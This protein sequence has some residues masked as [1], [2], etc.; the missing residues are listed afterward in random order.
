VIT[1]GISGFDTPLSLKGIHEI[2]AALQSVNTILSFYQTSN[3]NKNTPEIQEIIKEAIQYAN[4]NKDFENFDRLLFITR[5]INSL[6]QKLLV[7][8]K[9]LQIPVITNIY[10]LRGDIGTI[11][12]SAAFNINYFAPDANSYVSSAKISLGK[13]LFND[14]ILSDNNKISCASCHHPSKAFTDGFTKSMALGSAGFLGRNTPS[15]IN[16]GLQ[17]SQFYDMRATY[18]EDQVKNVIENK[19]EIHGS[20]KEAVIQLNRDSEYPGLF[21]TAFPLEKTGINE[22]VIQVAL[23]SYIRSLTSSNA[24]FD[25]YMRG[26]ITRMDSQEIKGFNVFMGKAKC[27]SCHF[28][29][30]FNGTV[31][32]TFTFTES[33]VIGV[34]QNKDGKKIDPD[35]GR[36]GIYQIENFRNAFKTPS[37][38]NV[39]LTA[40]YMH[41]GV[42]TTLAEVVDFYNNG[43]GIG[44]GLALKNQTLPEDSL[45]LT[46]HE[47]QALIAFMHTLTDT[48]MI[49]N[50][51]YK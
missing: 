11:F 27:G 3:Y 40:P 10:G 39:A 51:Y 5:F 14:P 4:A 7:L 34:P 9:D 21:K 20:L 28:M 44:I 22:R 33:E 12:D 48:S 17:K 30:L 37:V 13:Q 26:D 50:T 29:P 35:P 46:E 41:N 19:D 45:H 18:L 8:Q 6:T 32:P 1:L 47:K 31:P 36:F 23:S 43:G 15:L 2:P 49:A 38:R 42:F 24:R 25:Q 16:A